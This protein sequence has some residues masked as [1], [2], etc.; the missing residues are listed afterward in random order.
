M[1]RCIS[2]GLMSISDG[3]CFH[4]G[5]K[6]WRG[7]GSPMPFVRRHLRTPR[8]AVHG[9]RTEQD[10]QLGLSLP[11]LLE[12][13]APPANGNRERP[14]MPRR[15]RD[16]SVVISPASTSV[17]P[18]LRF[19]EVEVVRFRKPGKFWTRT[20]SS[21]WLSSAVTSARIEP[22]ESARGRTSRMMPYSLYWTSVEPSPSDTG[23][24]ISPPATNRATD[25]CDR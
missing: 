21:I 20:A 10:H 3:P 24:G 7:F 14:G 8:V 23:S 25:R 2:S 11:L 6:E 16:V 12:R 22:V 9:P 18:A 4:S 1:Q 13:N 5:G 19:T 17:S 15:S